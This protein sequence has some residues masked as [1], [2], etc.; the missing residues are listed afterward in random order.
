MTWQC[1]PSV[2]DMDDDST[3]MRWMT[4]LSFQA[5][6]PAL[7]GFF[8]RFPAKLQRA[9]QGSFQLRFQ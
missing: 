8:G 3:P 4:W 7:S 2:D 6:I 9:L 5:R 1:G